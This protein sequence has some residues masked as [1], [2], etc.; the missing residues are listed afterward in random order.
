MCGHRSLKIQTQDGP[1]RESSN[2]IILMAMFCFQGN[3]PVHHR[4]L[5]LVLT[6]PMQTCLPASKHKTYGEV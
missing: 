6:L 4:S 3:M 2:W 1:R 5:G